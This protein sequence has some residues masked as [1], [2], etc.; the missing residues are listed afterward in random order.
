MS[1]LVFGSLNLDLVVRTPRLPLPGETIAGRSFATIPGGK[2][3]NQAVA[4]ARLGAKTQMV[5]RVGGDAFGKQLLAS[6]R[7]NEVAI[8]GVTV[9]SEAHSGVAAIAASDRAD[10]Q[11]IVVPGANGRIDA[12]DCDRVRLLL[13]AATVLLLQL[14][15]PLPAVEAAARAA[16]T[17]GVR[18][19]LDPAPV[20]ET[21]ITPILKFVNW[22]TPNEVEASQLVGFEV[23]DPETAIRAGRELLAR[24]AEGAIVKLGSRGLVAVTAES[25]E[26]V[27]PFA[28]D[29][30]DTVAAGDAF[31]GAFA[32]AL[33]L[34]LSLS[35]ALLW[36]AA[37]GAL[38][39][40]VEGAQ[41]SLATREAV[42]ALLER[43]RQ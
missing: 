2:G 17:A 18:V 23:K 40:T 9:D 19:I 26:F 29:A 20:P 11:I 12:T 13:S 36:G 43:D 7:G 8:E 25:V 37:A 3:A 14:E 30:I 33:D 39:T 42:E 24:G 15:I 27:P 1:V 10:N 31:N 21:D 38:A 6:L 32:A 5:G 16:R 22:V 28:V 4:A 34:N 35:K 41:P